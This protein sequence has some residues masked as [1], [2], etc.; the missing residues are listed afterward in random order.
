M[1]GSIKLNNSF[2]V[3]IPEELKGLS[4]C[5]SRAE[6]DEKVQS[7]F[8]GINEDIFGKIIAQC[9]D[10]KTLLTLAYCVNK[11]FPGL[12]SKVVSNFS[13]G[14]VVRFCGPKFRMISLDATPL[15]NFKEAPLDKLKLIASCHEMNRH[16]EGNEGLSYIRME[17]GTT[18]NQ[19][20]EIAKDAK[21]NIHIWIDVWDR[22]M[23]AFGD[24][25]VEQTY[26]VLVTHNVFK[27]SRSKSYNDQKE[28]VEKL[29]CEFP[30]LLEAV[31][32]CIFTR[33]DF[34]LCLYEPNLW[35]PET[36][37]T[38]CFECIDTGPLGVGSCV[39]SR[40]FVRCGD[41]IESQDI[42]VGGRRES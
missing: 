22:V 25:P 10:A 35:R 41:Y 23:R 6:L 14:E 7:L 40:I 9:D 31:V 27:G 12:V 1:S 5:G 39:P 11:K 2:P 20:F 13:L 36:T 16:V 8:G 19:V 38:R 3:F 17:A 37:Y 26:G 42:G 33:R 24:R 34:E 15:F 18:L 4:S 30:R 21:I 32:L 29:K 28:L